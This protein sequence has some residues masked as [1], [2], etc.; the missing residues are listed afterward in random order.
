METDKWMPVCLQK[1]YNY[2]IYIYILTQCLQIKMLYWR[3]Y[4]VDITGV[5]DHKHYSC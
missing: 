1:D 4:H 2:N 3:K 5:I